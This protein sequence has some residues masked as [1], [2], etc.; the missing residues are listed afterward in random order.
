MKYPLV[1]HLPATGI[2]T[3]NLAILFFMRILQL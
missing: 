3:L 2:L 1:D